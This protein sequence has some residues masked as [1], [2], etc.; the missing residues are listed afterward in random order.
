M[1]ATGALAALVMLV[2]AGSSPA[3][4]T[5]GWVQGTH[6]AP[7][8]GYLGM[9]STSPYYTT[10]SYGMNGHPA[11]YYASWAQGAYPTYMTSINYPTIYGS[12]G[13]QYAPGRMTYGAVQA[14]YTT[15]PMVYGYYLPPQNSVSAWRVI[16]DTA[17]T[18]INPTASIDVRLPAD[19][20]LSFDGTQ[21]TQRGA[22]RH[23]VTPAL[24]PGNT[25]AYDI[26]ATWNQDGR[27]V[28][29][30]RHLTLRP[31]DHLTVDLTTPEPAA[32]STLKTKP[33][34]KQQ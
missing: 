33:L 11:Q 30:T 15:A 20:A 3:Q 10:Y 2:A 26:S 9:I 18:P 8:P 17:S 5:Y 7:S 6:Y 21:M 34:P 1:K 27:E 19:A 32:T 14:D 24:T 29:R 23:F 31:G 28:S 13:Y 16:P 25:Y 12:Y 22:L 4:M